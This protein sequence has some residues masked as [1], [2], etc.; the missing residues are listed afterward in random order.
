MSGVLNGA[1]A[2]GWT[3]EPR[4]WNRSPLLWALLV[5]IG[6]H[7]AGI[8]GWE[9]AR[10]I[11]RAF[12]TLFPQWVRESVLPKQEIARTDA[13]K[14]DPA[15]PRPPA[16]EDVEIPLTFIE[17]D[18]S[19]ATKEAPK[20]TRLYSTENTRAANPGPPKP[21]ATQPRIEGKRPEIPRTMDIAKPTPPAPAPA[22]AAPA[23]ETAK[24]PAPAAPEAKPQP[25]R[26]AQERVEKQDSGGLK[27]GEAQL[28]KANPDAVVPRPQ[29]RRDPREAQ[30]PQ[31]E[32][33]AQPELQ[34]VRRPIKRLAEAREQKGIIVGEKMQQEGGVERLAIESSMDV[35]AS[36]YGNYDRAFIAAVQQR[37]YSLLQ[38]HHYAFERGGKVTL[39]FKLRSDGA[40]ADMTQVESEVGD[41]WAFL[42][43]SAILTQSPFAR[44]PVE[45]RRM[46]GA[47]TREVTFTFH[48]YL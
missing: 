37:W 36:P 30:V 18:P 39:K 15:R 25:A 10:L 9:S 43:E 22:P 16:E 7:V 1:T 21:K 32:Q 35:R 6:L 28:A 5:S 34:P 13:L 31:P 45:M 26:I 46:V 33:L 4:R 38:E 47:D 3:E 14:P 17:V 48:Y 44:W 41:V 24:P 11:V 42:C 20:A 2:N 12:P 29:P 23:P 19:L 27:P 8:V 40:V